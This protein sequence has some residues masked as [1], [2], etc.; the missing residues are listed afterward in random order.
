MQ[1]HKLIL[2]LVVAL[3]LGGKTVYGQEK[4]A[5]K[6]SYGMVRGT[7]KEEKN[8]IRDY[9][10]ASHFRLEASNNLFDNLFAGCYLGYSHLYKNVLTGKDIYALTSTNAFY[11]GINADYRLLSL[12]FNNVN[13]RFDL[14]PTLKLGLVT[15]FWKEPYKGVQDMSLK[16]KNNTS[17][18]FGAGLGSFY[19]ITPNFGVFGEYTWGKFYNN[20]NSRFHIGFL[21]NF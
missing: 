21:F 17:F 5:V 18:E 13:N 19:K 16:V 20:S 8:I 15:E 7:D 9:P 4:W 11:Y 6:L 10:T 2:L 3:L 1:T 14:Y 12:F